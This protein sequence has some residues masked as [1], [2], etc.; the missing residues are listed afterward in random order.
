MNATR[1]AVCMAAVAV[2]SG[3]A[4]VPP[5]ADKPRPVSPYYTATGPLESARAYLYG[6]TTLVELAAPASSLKVRDAQD[7]AVAFD[8]MGRFVRLSRPVENF[9][10]WADGQHATFAAVPIVRVLDAPPRQAQAMPARPVAAAPTPAVLVPVAQ[11][12][13][14]PAEVVELLALAQQQAQGLARMLPTSSNVAEHQDIRQRLAALDS[15]PAGKSAAVLHVSFGLSS[16]AFKPNPAQARVL[17]AAA[18]RA[19]AIHLRGF[20]DSRI[21]GPLDARIAQGRAMAARKYLM[22]NGVPAERITVSSVAEGEFIAP[23]ATA[24]G[25]AM[26]RRVSIEFTDSAIGDRAAPPAFKVAGERP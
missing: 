15:Q 2:L 11:A 19:T 25:K 1:L 7:Q 3:C 6:S 10:V 4:Y 26:N 22:D 16:I 20:T 24:E 21:A 8:A 18:K 14:M 5:A 17:L 13:P 23:S 12:K 9:T